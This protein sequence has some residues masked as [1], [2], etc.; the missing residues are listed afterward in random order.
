MSKANDLQRLVGRLR[1]LEDD[2]APDGWPAVQMRDISALLDALEALIED[3]ARFPDR[4]D[5]IG[6]MIQGHIGSL[7]AG[8]TATEDACRR[9]DTRMRRI[10]ADIQRI[11]EL[12][13][14]DA[15]EPFD[16]ALA[17][18]DSLLPP[19]A[20]AQPAE[21]SEARLQRNVV[22]EDKR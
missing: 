14:S 8:K 15:G 19:N 11:A 13:Y 2:H 17:I 4:P 12:R 1:A 9:L 10:H 3:R 18:A 20:Q 6:R 22:R 16:E 21:R 5:F 7:R